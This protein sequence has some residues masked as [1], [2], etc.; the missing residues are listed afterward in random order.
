MPRSPFRSTGFWLGVILLL[1]ALS[2][3]VGLLFFHRGGQTAVITQNGRELFRIDLSRVTE[4]QTLEITG[5][6]HNTVEI[7]PGR[8]RVRE[9]DCPDQICVDT[10]WISDGAR[11]IV[12]LPNRL[13]IEIEGGAQDAD[14]AVH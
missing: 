10:G 2:A 12:C 1:L 9:A 4:V 8:I 14:I 5:A 6:C 7:E 11:P 3:A 13:V